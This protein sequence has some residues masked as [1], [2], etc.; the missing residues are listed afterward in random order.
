MDV[1][2]DNRRADASD[3]SLLE[4]I[5]M[6]ALAFTHRMERLEGIDGDAWFLFLGHMELKEIVTALRDRP[7]SAV[8]RVTLPY[9]EEMLKRTQSWG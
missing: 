7:D 2:E 5:D 6:A 1:P 4:Q 8:K 9:L 3:E